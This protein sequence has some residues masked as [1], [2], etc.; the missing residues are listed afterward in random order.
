MPRL[1]VFDLDGTLAESTSPRD[2][3]MSRLLGALLAIVKVAIISG[4]T[5][6]QFDI[7]VLSKVQQDEHMTHVL[8]LPRCGITFHRCLGGWAPTTSRRPRLDP[9]RPIL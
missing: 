1:I 8:V 7:R 5:S 9:C 4:G 2:A 3:E 6:S